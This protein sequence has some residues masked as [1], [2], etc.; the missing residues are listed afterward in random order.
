MKYNKH[1]DSFTGVLD[2]TQRYIE[3]KHNSKN[4]NDKRSLSLIQYTHKVDN[5]HN[6]EWSNF[7]KIEQLVNF[8]I[9]SNKIHIT[10][11]IYRWSVD[12][13]N[14]PRIQSFIASHNN[15]FEEV[16]KA[17]P[18][19]YS[20]IARPLLLVLKESFW[21][22][23]IESYFI[24][25]HPQCM[26]FNLVNF[27]PKTASES[28][29][30]AIY[31][32]GFLMQPDHHEEVISYMQT[33]A[34]CNIKKISFVAKL[35]SVQALGIYAYALGLTGNPSLSRL[36]LSH[37]FRIGDAIGVSI[38][39]K[40]IPELDQYNR[41][42]AYSEMLI[43]KN[44]TKLGASTYNTLSEKDDT[45]ID[46]YNPKYQL[47][48]PNLS[49]HNNDHERTIY[50][51]FCSELRKSQIQ[52]VIVN[53]IIC[54]YY[55]NRIDMEIDELN[56]KTNEIYINSK[57][58]LE[59]MCHVYTEYKD[60]IRNYISLIKI[61][62]LIS[63]LGIHCKM[64]ESHRNINFSTIEYIINKCTEIW[65]TLSKDKSLIHIWRY[66]PFTAAFHLIKVYPYSTKMQRE[67]I[68]FILRSI[69]DFY[70]KEGLDVNSI[71]F[72]IL[73]TQADLYENI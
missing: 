39:R 65:G 62:Y 13:K 23:L 72:L 57:I 64:I 52:C 12:L 36:C 58:R 43:Y 68:L 27:D 56:V 5:I 25:F 9:Y 51:I 6:Y 34:I 71:D 10:E 14:V 26:L 21:D 40:N 4:L 67:T 32:A 3:S 29:L 55:P 20:V 30:S 45:D 16:Y 49:L 31:Y 41:K 42:I 69:M 63:T 44:W 61:P 48:S 54:N 53:N 28:L 11:F 8:I 1:S 38:K 15:S 22:S 47:S 60:L 24:Y 35:S 70:Y 37:L 46:I 73:K 7:K 66:G 19:Y 18:Q 33:Y 17:K 59:A 50:S 2:V